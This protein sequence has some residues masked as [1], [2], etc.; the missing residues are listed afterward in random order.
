[1]PPVPAG[2]AVLR[3][4]E[5]VVVVPLVVVVVVVGKKTISKY[6]WVVV[7]YGCGLFWMLE[8][9]IYKDHGEIFNSFIYF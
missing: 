3:R 5:K 8:V 9:T 4:P 2:S 6:E 7:V 1:M